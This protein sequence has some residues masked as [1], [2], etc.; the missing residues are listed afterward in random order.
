MKILPEDFPHEY[1]SPGIHFS[2][3]HEQTLSLFS[4][5]LKTYPQSFFEN[6]KLEASYKEM[7]TQLNNLE[8]Y[9]DKLR[10]NI[11]N[12]LSPV[13]LDYISKHKFISNLADFS[14]RIIEIR[15][16]LIITRNLR[17]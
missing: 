11:F 4:L 3:L 1:I 13:E 15:E 8:I 12:F 17:P 6:I 5:C 10:E 14:E 9:F 7:L 16:Q 2:H